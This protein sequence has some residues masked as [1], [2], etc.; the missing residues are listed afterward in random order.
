MVAAM[1]RHLHSLRR[2]KR[3]HG[4][5][6]TLLGMDHVTGYRNVIYAGLIAKGSILYRIVM[7]HACNI[8]LTRR[9]GNVLR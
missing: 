8:K 6:H 7:I 9:R 2:L 1:T 4:W 5:I 3:D